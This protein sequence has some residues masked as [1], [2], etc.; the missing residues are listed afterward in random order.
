MGKN[1]TNAKGTMI[2][3]K[4]N[5]FRQIQN[6]KYLNYNPPRYISE[7]APWCSGNILAFGASVASS[8]LAGAALAPVV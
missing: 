2:N 3:L 7:K 4:I 5:F 8:N 6:T 1:S